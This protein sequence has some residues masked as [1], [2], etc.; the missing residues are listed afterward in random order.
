MSGNSSG[1]DRGCLAACILFTVIAGLNIAFLFLAP[2]EVTMP[3]FGNR[4]SSLLLT[5]AGIL[6]T[7]LAGVMS[8]FSPHRKYWFAAMVILTLADTILLA[9]F[10]IPE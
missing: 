7:G 1:F 9:S 2:T 6:V 8:V 10:L 4:I 3:L 5:I